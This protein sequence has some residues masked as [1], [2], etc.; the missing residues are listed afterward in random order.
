M[1]PALRSELWLAFTDW[2]HFSY[3]FLDKDPWSANFPSRMLENAHFE[4]DKLSSDLAM[5][6]D[7]G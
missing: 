7:S 1:V 6:C 2:D 5:S 3:I 4:V